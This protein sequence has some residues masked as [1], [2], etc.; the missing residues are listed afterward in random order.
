MFTTANP[1][2]TLGAEGRKTA[3][4]KGL[5]GGTVL[6]YALPQVVAFLKAK[7]MSDADAKRVAENLA[8]GTQKM[9]PELEAEMKQTVPPP[10]PSPIAG[11][12]GWAIPV[13]IGAALIGGMMYMMPT[14]GGS[15]RRRR[16]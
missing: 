9:S 15:R 3:F 6:G 4:W 1:Y 14:R 2:N 13:G 5:I 8:A 12:P 11:L 7:G 10:P 16:R